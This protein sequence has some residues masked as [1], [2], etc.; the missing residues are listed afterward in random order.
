MKKPKTV[1]AAEEA[2]AAKTAEVVAAEQAL[3]RLKAERTE[4]Y[5]AV[6]NA[7]TEADATLPQCRMVRVRGYNGKVEGGARYV[8]VRRT[9]AGMLVVRRVGDSSGG[10]SRFKWVEA[11]SVYREATKG[12]GWFDANELRD[13]PAEYMPADALEF[14]AGRVEA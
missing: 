8:I 9:P 12:R 4:A 6:V 3:E 13:V 14:S 7:Q 2:L 11:A 10:E 5:A 1:I